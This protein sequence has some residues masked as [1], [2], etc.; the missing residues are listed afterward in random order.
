MKIISQEQVHE[1]H[2]RLQAI[3]ADIEARPVRLLPD[4]PQ[5]HQDFE[6]A[7]LSAIET[8]GVNSVRLDRKDAVRGGN[9]TSLRYDQQIEGDAFQIHAYL[10]ALDRMPWVTRSQTLSVEAKLSHHRSQ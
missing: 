8:S 7:L 10:D 6:N 9:F 5:G 4:N 2:E 3:L 1:A